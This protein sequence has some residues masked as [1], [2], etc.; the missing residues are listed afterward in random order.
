[1]TEEE[2]I[3]DEHTGALLP[4][5]FPLQGAKR[6]YLIFTAAKGVLLAALI[7]STVSIVAVPAPSFAEV[8]V[9]I[10]VSFAPPALPVYVQPPPPAPDYIW[11]PGYWAWDPDYGY[12]WVPGTW[13]P[14]PYPGWLW[15][16]GYWGWGNGIYIWNEG[17]W[18]P[19]VGYYGGINYGCGYNG[20]GYY[21]GYWRGRHFYYNRAV[22]N[23]GSN[24]TTVYRS[25]VQRS[26]ARQVSFS[27]GERGVHVRPTSAQLAAARGRGS[28]PITPQREHSQA[29]RRDPGLRA[30][31]NHGRPGIAATVRPGAL[32]GPGVVPAKRAGA[33]Y[34]APAAHQPGG[35]EKVQGGAPAERARHEPAPPN[36]QQAAPRHE[37]P[38][39]TTY[40]P[41]A[42]PRREER[43]PREF[44]PPPVQRR[45][46]PAVREFR[47]PERAPAR[48]MPRMA[49]PPMGGPAEPRGAPREAPPA[50]HGGGGPREEGGHVR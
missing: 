45:E 16:P 26:T 1:M 22:N 13:V 4:A 10:S 44:A 28:G 34:R 15:T 14:A 11:V 24:V 37:R 40:R 2:T 21:G 46:P 29:A 7:L 43:A 33:P 36:R 12:Y 50:P 32:S 42:E 49:P 31:A 35:R 6:W 25:P 3:R 39:A 30:S 9:G 19:V 38:G 8:S 5:A 48:E 17:Y 20:Y 18:G 41:P 47:P 27:G 23:V